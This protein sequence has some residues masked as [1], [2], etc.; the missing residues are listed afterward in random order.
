MSQPPIQTLG[1]RGRH[2]ERHLRRAHAIA[3]TPRHQGPRW[4]TYHSGDAETIKRCLW[5][6]GLELGVRL[7]EPDQ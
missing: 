5:E 3:N 7:W 1:E 6:I 2:V 4:A